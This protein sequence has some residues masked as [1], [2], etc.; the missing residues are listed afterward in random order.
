MCFGCGCQINDQFILRVAPDLEWHAKCLKCFECGKFLDESCTCFVRNGK[1]YCKQDYLRLFSKKCFKCK[2]GFNR[3]DFV[4]R[5]NQQIFHIDCFRCFMC[6]KQLAPGD[7][8]AF[9]N[10][11]NILCKLDNELY[12]KHMLNNGV[13]KMVT[14]SSS[15]PSNILG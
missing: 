8:F 10:E 14:N 1:A 3:N 4:M 11:G 7:E 12:E 9:K 2:E 15:T 6:D 5:A 13:S